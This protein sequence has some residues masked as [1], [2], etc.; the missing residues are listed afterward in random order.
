MRL[1][2]LLPPLTP[3]PTTFKEFAAVM[4]LLDAID[5]F[6][7]EISLLGMPLNVSNPRDSLDGASDL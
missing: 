6:R 5:E 2:F 3:P 7:E 1:A 4:T